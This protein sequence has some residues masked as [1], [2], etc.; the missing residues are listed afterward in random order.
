MLESIQLGT[1]Y[2]QS[3]VDDFFSFFFTAQWAAIF[4]DVKLE[5]GGEVPVTLASWRTKVGE[6]KDPRD[7][8]SMKIMK[9]KDLKK[10]YHGSFM[11][12][13]QPF[14]RHWRTKLGFL[15]RD[16]D[17]AAEEIEQSQSF[18]E[19]CRRLFCEYTDRAVIDIIESS[20]EAGMM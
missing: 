7:G 2:L 12:E 11:C 14:L 19:T 18:E 9:P 20:F 13:V 15:N 16:W 3:P 4:N 1:P 17:R 10:Q 5:A 6:G 8:V